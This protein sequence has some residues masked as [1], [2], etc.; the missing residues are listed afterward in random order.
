MTD[1]VHHR[2]LPRLWLRSRYK[3]EENR[4]KN[5]IRK[6][7]RKLARQN[8]TFDFSDF[9]GKSK[10]ESND[11]TGG[12]PIASIRKSIYVDESSEPSMTPQYRHFSMAALVSE[13]EN[14]L[15]EIVDDFPATPY[16][17][18]YCHAK[19]KDPIG[20][21]CVLDRIVDSDAEIYAKFLVKAIET[22]RR[23]PYQ[24]YAQTL[25]DLIDDVL[26]H[27]STSVFDLYVDKQ[28][29]MLYPDLMRIFA[30]YPRI[31]VHDPL[32]CDGM[33]G[34]RLADF[35]AGASGDRYI[36]NGKQLDYYGAI[37]QKLINKNAKG[38][39]EWSVSRHSASSQGI[40]VLPDMHLIL[41]QRQRVKR[42]WRWF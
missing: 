22:D 39:S 42:R 30:D 33:P 19:D 21:Y 26:A 17:Y 27:D 6:E 20:C 11:G 37:R 32:D 14:E 28:T 4:R 12:K 24:V 25:R 16:E 29:Y 9:E 1:Y 23:L 15:A 34:L 41:I 36:D 8:K 40:I 10:Y 2:I 5:K 38:R 31:V 3:R 7:D 18:K 13:N 35:I